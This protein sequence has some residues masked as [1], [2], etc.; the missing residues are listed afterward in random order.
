MPLRFKTRARCLQII[1]VAGA[2]TL[3]AGLG[4]LAIQEP[5]AW[6][7]QV[8]DRLYG[9]A[10]ANGRGPGLSPDIVYLTISDHSYS[11]LSKQGLDRADLARAL[12]ALA[13]LGP[14]A[15]VFDMIFA[16]PSNPQ[17][18]NALADSLKN[19]GNAYLPVGLAFGDKPCPFRWE[20]GSA[21]DVLRRQHL[22]TPQEK[23]ASRAHFAFRAMVQ[24]DPFALAARGGGHI[25]AVSDADGVY[26]RLPLLIRLDQGYL[27]A[28]ALAV[29]LDRMG[30]SLSQV[31]VEWGRR[32]VIPALKGS[33]LA[34]DVVIPIDARG[35]AVIPF[36]RPWESDFAKMELHNLLAYFQDEGLRGNLIDFF[37]GK[38]VLVADVATGAADLGQTPLE[39]N[40]PLVTI[41][42][43]ILNGL[44]TGTFYTAHGMGRAALAL[45][46][47]GLVLAIAACLKAE[48]PLYLAG[49]LAASGLAGYTWHQILHFGLFPLISALAGSAIVFGGLVVFL[50]A[51][52]AREKAFIQK[53]FSCYL[54]PAVVNRLIENPELLKLGGETRTLTILFS[55]LAGFTTIAEKT[56]TKTLVGLLND[57][58]TEMTAIV[59]SHGGIIDK[60]QG[61]AIMA[62]F[63]APIPLPDHAE[64]AVA[65]GLAMLGRL[66]ELRAKWRRQGLPE[67]TCRIG[68]NTGPVI[69]GN[70]G[71]DQVFDYT[72]IGDAVNLAARLEGANKDFGTAMMISEFTLAY[73]TPGRFKTRLLDTITVKGKS[74]AVKVYEVMGEA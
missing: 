51:A 5:T 10:I 2:L 67:L 72:V 37:E 22:Q 18:D 8:L 26:R 36:A 61:D 48:W 19:A 41:H 63:G 33:R 49:I 50:K 31:Q 74:E 16:R 34:K 32:L 11:A 54:P 12:D 59:I 27:P 65:A 60:Y 73:L 47:A 13:R 9:L 1:A 57:Y 43:A 66:A 58:L 20:P 17:A 71:S 46:L 45:V 53:A 25:S 56:D 3:A 30:I 38:Y 39:D 40:A 4:L 68:I 62:E 35:R 55:D 64:R 24:H 21:F 42:A 44:L 29:F 23:G 6:D 14:A 28:L 7:R 52:T 69:L 15:V 70:M